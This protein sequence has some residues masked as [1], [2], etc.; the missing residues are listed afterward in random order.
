MSVIL[1]PLGI[2]I[3]FF[4]SEVIW[5]WSGDMEIARNTVVILSL[6]TVGVL[7]SGMGHIPGSVQLAHGW[8]AL[9]FFLNLLLV[10]AFVPL[11][12]LATNLYGVIGAAAVSMGVY[13]VYIVIMMQ[14]MHRRMLKGALKSWYIYD[15]GLPLVGALLIVVAARLL[16]VDDME[17]IPTALFLILL[18]VTTCL[19]SILFANTLRERFLGKTAVLVRGLD[20]FPL[21]GPRLVWIRRQLALLWR[22]L[23]IYRPFA[24][25]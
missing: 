2:V 1:L 10:L 14:L 12:L 5:V 9:K 11:M 16:V 21:I 18:T 6:L 24:G 17:R 22:Q 7:L 15:I 8:T 4:S 23:R 13:A 19:T 3:I 25:K 20:D